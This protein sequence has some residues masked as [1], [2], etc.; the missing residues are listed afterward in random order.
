MPWFHLLVPMHVMT[1][2][3]GMRPL[4]ESSGRQSAFASHLVRRRWHRLREMLRGI[5]GVAPPRIKQKD[6]LV[7]RSHK[8]CGLLQPTARL[9][10]QLRSAL[11]DNRGERDR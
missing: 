9:E 1:Q 7:T 5:I 4:L 11:I 3:R 6:N 10:R 8:N 2:S